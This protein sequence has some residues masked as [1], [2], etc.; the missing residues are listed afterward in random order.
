MVLRTIRVKRASWR[1]PASPD[2]LLLTLNPWGQWRWI[3]GCHH[4]WHLIHFLLGDVPSTCCHWGFGDRVENIS[5][6]PDAPEPAPGP[7]AT[8]G[9][10]G[11]RLIALMV[12]DRKMG[13][14][15]M[16]DGARLRWPAVCHR[17]RL[18]LQN[19]VMWPQASGRLSAWESM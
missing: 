11:T 7:L 10:R 13:L 4:S 16:V 9:L 18:S 5:L 17:G 2:G 3:S 19:T 12:Q 1:C 6:F 14:I 15:L 8:A